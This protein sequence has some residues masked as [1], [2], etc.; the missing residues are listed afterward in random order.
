MNERRDQR[1]ATLADIF[2]WID[3]SNVPSCGWCN[4]RRC[5]ECMSAHQRVRLAKDAAERSYQ[6]AMQ[7]IEG[8]GDL[9]PVTEGALNEQFQRGYQ[10]ASQQY[11]QD[12]ARMEHELSRVS[13]MLAVRSAQVQFQQDPVALERARLAGYS[14]GVQAGRAM[15]TPAPAPPSVPNPGKARADLLADVMRETEVIGQSNPNMEPAMNALRHR[16]KKLG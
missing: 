10:T 15:A 12:R 6:I 9:T 8:R 4:R 5:L 16:V 7:E 2:D 3:R 14:A 13:N 1:H 11:A